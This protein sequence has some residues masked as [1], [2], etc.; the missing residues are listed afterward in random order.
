MEK[1]DPSQHR[2]NMRWD[3]PSVKISS[4]ETAWLWDGKPKH[5]T[6]AGWGH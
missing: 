5:E 1:G 3:N 6:G 2:V 4:C